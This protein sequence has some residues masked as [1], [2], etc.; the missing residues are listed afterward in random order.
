[1]H[2][3]GAFIETEQVFQSETFPGGFAVLINNFNVLLGVFRSGNRGGGKAH[4]GQNS[5]RA[6]AFA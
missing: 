5:F 1:L 6:C 2:G 4:S 3:A